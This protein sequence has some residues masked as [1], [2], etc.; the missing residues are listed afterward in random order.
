MACLGLWLVRV[1]RFNISFFR[2]SIVPV[3]LFKNT[4]IGKIKLFEGY[5]RLTPKGRTEYKYLNDM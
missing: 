1:A 4:N 3:A 2:M 5:T